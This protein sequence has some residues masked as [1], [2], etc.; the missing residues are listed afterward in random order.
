[1][2]IGLTGGDGD[3]AGLCSGY[4]GSRRARKAIKDFI[5]LTLILLSMAGASL[6]T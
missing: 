4:N 2:A 5:L 1:M 3:R 6:R